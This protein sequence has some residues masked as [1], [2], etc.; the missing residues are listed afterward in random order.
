MRA[1]VQDFYSD[2]LNSVRAG[3]AAE[4]SFT[5]QSFV[6]EFARRLTEAEEVDNLTAGHFE[7]VGINQRKIGLDGY[8]FGDEEG[9]VVL[10]IS[11][12]V[13]S[14]TLET[15]GTTDA[16]RL[17]GLVVGFI[18]AALS[19]DFARK[20][21][22][23]SV[24][25]QVAKQLA[26]Q[27]SRTFKIRVYMLTNCALGVQVKGFTS[28]E[29]D[30]ITVEFHPW[31]IQ[32]LQ[33]VQAS[34]S[35]RE[36]I[37]IDLNEWQAGGLPCL[38]APITS[39]SVET[40][41]CV[42]PASVLAGVYMKY[43]SR[44]LESNV[45]SFLSVRGNVNKGIRG[46]LMKQ[47][48]MFLSFNNGITATAT[49]V[50]TETTAT[51]IS[52]TRIRDLQI[53]NGGQTTASIFY[54]QKDDKSL[55]LADVFV[56]MKLIVVDEEQESE[57]VPKISR[58]AN[59]QNRISDADFFSNHPF[60]QRMEEKS[61][62]ILA[63]SVA[64]SPFQTKWFYER[65][66]G[67]FATERSRLG[68][69]GL[70][71]FDLEN[72][73]AQLLTKTDAARYLVSWSQM[74]HIVSGGA[75]K[76]FIQF[77]KEIDDQWTKDDNQFGD[78]YF[79]EL[80]AKGILFNG[81]RARVLKADWYKQEPG[82]LA[83][84]VTYA[85]AKLGASV[86][87]EK[88]GMKFNLGRVWAEQSFS[89]ELWGVLESIAILVRRTLTDPGRPVVN[90]TEWAKREACWAAMKS[91]RLELGR[92]VDD[93]LVSA[94][95]VAETV[96]A[97][98]QDQRMVSGIDGQVHIHKQGRAYWSELLEFGTKLRAVSPKESDLLKLAA[99]PAGSLMTELQAKVVVAFEKRMVGS[100]FRRN[101][102]TD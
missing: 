48:E 2:F 37:E 32:R 47:P 25:Y 69:A 75:Q 34:G 73:K 22:E 66:R 31:D 18:E 51:G 15:L 26:D 102:D 92:A 46:T 24:G 78:D 86:Q 94:S 77:A 3:A 23:S 39:T 88:S 1:D 89:D 57:I 53:V 4:G 82:Y 67:Q 49:A 74:P 91:A 93:Y 19:P 36:E 35:G 42:V 99:G 56:Q 59:T 27:V 61:R 90:V 33:R 5:E 45:R 41:L 80:V 97:A 20:L 70:R 6:E 12:F 64:G 21:E 7:G 10:A 54:S 84:I 79:R 28:R 14:D 55:D 65:T 60:H 81:I 68:T 63:P 43:G 9:H 17:F 11:H 95:S 29:V 13:N 85:V 62:R 30:G 52:L 98:R 71:Q 16:N 100:G 101:A 38:K 8:D 58:F 96:R 83:N 72:P 50:K 76:N 40:Y 44:V 87:S